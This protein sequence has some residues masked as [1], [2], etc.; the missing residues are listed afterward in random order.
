MKRS[1]KHVSLDVWQTLIFSNEEFRK[2]RNQLLIKSFDLRQSFDQVSEIVKN[3]QAWCTHANQLVGKN[4]DSFE[5]L[6]LILQDCGLS[7]YDV[8]IYTL[9]TYYYEIEKLFL[10]Y[11]PI[12]IDK[13][14]KGILEK[15]KDQNIGVNLLSNTG[16]I[17]GRSLRTFF[18]Q[19]NL[20]S[21]FD[22]QLYSDEVGV[23]KPSI[24]FFD[25]VFEK[26]VGLQ[27]ILP[28]QIIH[29]GDNKVADYEG[30]LKYG[31]NVYLV[32]H[33]EVT[34]TNIFLK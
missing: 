28:S 32:D 9:E 8:S 21:Y 30:G 22:F 14:L 20:S 23:S 6:L 26:A 4:F 29:V 18:D 7:I 11:P 12:V 24:K 31:F 5:I 3:R 15:F 27:N 25:L 17:K 2:K 13:N 33:K 34:L 10:E 16:L 1:F 19:I